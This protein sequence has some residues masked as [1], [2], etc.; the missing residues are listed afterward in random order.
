MECPGFIRTIHRAFEITPIV[1]LRG[2][3]QCGKTTLAR[4]F[5]EEW[6]KDSP[7][8]NYF[9]LEHP[10]DL[11]RL[12]DAKLALSDLRGLIAI[13]EVQLRPELFPVLRTLID[14]PDRP[15]RFLILASASRDL[16]RQGAES[17]AGRISFVSSKGS[18]SSSSTEVLL[19]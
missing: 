5:I 6:A 18:V 4:A 11:S 2:P 12:V 3:R 16:I 10:T 19:A 7:P 17:L 14:R 8:S 13:D 15:A 1:A 9:D